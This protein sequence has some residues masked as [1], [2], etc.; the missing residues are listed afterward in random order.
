MKRKEIV[1]EFDETAYLADSLVSRN[2]TWDFIKCTMR[3][4]Y[5][6]CNGN[7]TEI[8]NEIKK[9]RNLKRICKDYLLFQ[10]RKEHITLIEREV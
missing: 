4:V 10:L 3:G 8:V 6:R 9:D 1:F 7:I 2:Y 5:S